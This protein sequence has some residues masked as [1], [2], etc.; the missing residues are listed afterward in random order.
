MV[1]HRGY[2]ESAWRM[3]VQRVWRGYRE[4]TEIAYRGIQSAQR[5]AE[6]VQCGMEGVQ[7]GEGRLLLLI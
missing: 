2:A 3:S 5:G 4:C 6:S 7:R 1:G